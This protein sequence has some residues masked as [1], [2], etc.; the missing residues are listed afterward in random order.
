MSRISRGQLVSVCIPAFNGARWLRESLQSAMGQTY[1]RLE[2]LVVD[3]CSSDDTLEVARSFDDPRLRVVANSRNVGLVENWNRCV[4]L[5]RGEYVKFLFQ[6][7][8]LYPTC[9]ET[10]LELLSREL[11]VGLTFSPRS[12]IVEPG[13]EEELAAG[14]VARNATLHTRFGELASINSGRGLFARHARSLVDDLPRGSIW[15]CIGEPSSVMLRRSCFERIGLFNPRMRQACD[16]E[17]WLRFMFFFD[18]GF[19]PETL[20]AFRVHIASTTLANQRS[21][22]YLDDPYWLLEGLLSHDEIRSEHPELS[23]VRD[24]LV[25]RNSPF[26]P[27]AGWRSISSSGGLAAARADAL[28]VPSRIRLLLRHIVQRARSRAGRSLLPERLG[29]SSSR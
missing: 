15:C 28:G 17:M 23:R 25:A 16:I 14:W 2:I 24:E 8:V 5:A 7:D 12:L 10:L 21:R 6:D 9:V 27:S 22:A 3:D 11:R 1:E 29:P 13:A 19:I 4:R 18:I 20:S 26:R